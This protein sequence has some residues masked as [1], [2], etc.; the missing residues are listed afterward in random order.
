MTAVA[1]ASEK[2][3]IRLP[4]ALDPATVAAGLGVDTRVGLGAAEARH[5]ASTAGPTA[6][7]TSRREPLWR[8]LLG[9]AMEPFVLLLAVA[10]GLAILVGEVRDGLLVLVGLVPIVGADVITEY[11]GERAL[12]ALREA[13]APVARVRRDGSAMTVAASELVPG[14]VVLLQVG[15]VVPADLRISGSER[16]LLDRSVLTGESIPEEGRVN[17]DPEDAGLADRRAIAYSGTSVVGGRGEGVVVAIGT[18]TEFGQIAGSLSA[19][20]RRRSPLQRELDRLVRILLV[21]AIALIAFT[22]GIGFLR[23]HS[24]GENVVAGISSAIA[25]IPE[26]PPVLLAVILGLGAYRL[27]K[28]GVLVRRLNAEETLGAVDLIV[29]DK[30][31]TLTQNHLAISSVRTPAGSVEPGLVRQELLQEALRAEED[32]WPGDEIEASSFTR[33]LRADV[34]NAGG[35]TVLDATSL[36]AATPASEAFPVTRTQARR[37]GR[38]ED[39][40]LGAPEFVLA[41]VEADSPHL[42]IGKPWSDLIEASTSA[43]ERLVA[44]ARRIDDGP[45]QMRALVGFAD[46]IRPGIAAAMSAAHSAGIQV[47]VVTGDHPRTAAA[48]AREANLGADSIVTG[49]ELASWADEELGAKL[50]D[51]HVV[52]RSSPAQKLRLVR[53]ARSRGRIVAVTGDGVNDA[54]ALHGSDVAVAMGSGTAVAREASD[55]V[56]GDDSFATLMFGLAEGRRIVDNVQKGLVFLIS[57]HF[58]FLGFILISTIFV[59]ERQVL[60]PLQILWMELFI[61]LSTSVAF[62]REPAEPHLMQRSPRHAAKPLLTNQILAKIVAAG[63]FTAVAALVLMLTHGGGFQHAAWL[64]YTTLVVC[65]CVRAYW[66]RS[67]REPIHRLGPNGFLLGACIVAIAIQALIPYVP[68]FAEAFRATTLDLGDWLLVAIVA[69][70]PASAAEIARVRGHGQSIWVA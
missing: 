37:D 43:G 64:A 15:D 38:V 20:E 54:P 21:V 65:Q 61:D 3:M 25:A 51:L 55:L 58:A 66:N 33:A 34:A 60:I 18:A 4:H 5:R 7:E 35:N 70:V 49:A 14:D 63:S 10:G 28:R 59:V 22:S 13:S 6:L 52:A 48:I 32:A 30:T 46:P 45:W 69:L 16:L 53:A 23:G 39:L 68:P 36:V 26:E 50:N 67:V 29:T 9:A 41:F 47:V 42:T 44:L 57:T 19:H 12:E 40:A 27:L 8:M 17:P 62:E 1:D 24:L 2:F 11:R 31:G 56:L